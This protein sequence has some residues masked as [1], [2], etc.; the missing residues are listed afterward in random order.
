V[1]TRTDSRI[2]TTAYNASKYRRST[3]NNPSE[4]VLNNRKSTNEARDSIGANVV[5]NLAR[6][7]ILLN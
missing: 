2:L 7:P 3:T 6:H 5:N 4:P 1:T